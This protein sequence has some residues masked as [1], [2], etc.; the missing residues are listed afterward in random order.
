[1]IPATS[2]NRV[3]F[4]VNLPSGWSLVQGYDGYGLPD[5]ERL[6]LL[7]DSGYFRGHIDHDGDVAAPLWAT[8]YCR[9]VLNPPNWDTAVPERIKDT[10]VDVV[11]DR[12]KVNHRQP[13]VFSQARVFLD[14]RPSR[15]GPLVLPPPGEMERWL[16]REHAR[17]EAGEPRLD[18]PVYRWLHENH[19]DWRNPL[20][21]W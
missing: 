13:A 5:G 14:M 6:H 2:L 15:P 8:F 3:R 16:E 17:V 21:Y 19:P 9:Y 4:E 7:D 18:Q 1:M 11:I 10:I 20:A 12:T